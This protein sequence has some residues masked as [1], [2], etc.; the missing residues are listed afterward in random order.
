M[1]VIGRER[2]QE[3]LVVVLL[4]INHL[5]LNMLNE[6]VESDGRGR[7]DH[8]RLRLE[9]EALNLNESE[10]ITV[11]TSCIATGDRGFAFFEFEVTRRVVRNENRRPHDV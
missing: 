1:V 4:K 5:E 3:F 9:V 6:R 7:E 10:L 11:V 8:Q 2:L